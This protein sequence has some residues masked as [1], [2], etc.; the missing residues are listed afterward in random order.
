VARIGFG[1]DGEVT[2]I[3]GG[4][5]TA[6]YPTVYFRRW[7]SLSNASS[8]TNLV[9]RLQRDDGAVVHV[10]GVEA[11]RSNLPGGSIGFGT[12][13]STAVGDA[14][15]TTF[16]ETTLPAANLVNGTN[17]VAVEVHQSSATSS[18]LGFDL[19]L[20][21]T[22]TPVAETPLIVLESSGAGLKLSWPESATGYELYS[23]SEIGSGA[24][25][26]RV[27][28]PPAVSNGRKEVLIIPGPGT[29]FY[30]LRNP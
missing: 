7:F 21:G 20:L 5:S 28:A 18:D 2:L 27:T 9:F 8:V 22:G 4:P 17:L 25:W 23:S 29:Q 30:Q 15:E 1:N 11:Y 16:F 14:D 24:A 19:E 6:R 26:T 13:A 10:N 3:N 12:L